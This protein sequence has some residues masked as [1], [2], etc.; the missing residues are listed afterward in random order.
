MNINHFKISALIVVILTL[1]TR[2]YQLET[3]PPHLSNDEISIAYDAYSIA[4]TGR[5]E[6]N[7]ILPLSFQSHNTYK[8]PLYIYLTAPLTLI[9]PNTIT[10]A[11]LLSALVGSLTVILTGLLVFRLTSTH[12]L[13]LFSSA[14]LALTPWHIFTSRLALEANLALFFLILGIYLFV[15]AS[16]NRSSLA[17]LM[18]A[19]LSLVASMYAYHSEWILSPL[20]FIFLSFSYLR[21]DHSKLFLLFSL[22]ILLSLPLLSDY[23]HN[24]NTTVRAN[25]ELIWREASLKRKLDN[26]DHP[27]AQILL[28]TKTI[29]ENYLDH[30]NPRHLF[31]NGLALFEPNHPYQPGLF[32]FI[33]L[34]LFVLGWFGLTVFGRYRNLVIFLALIS[35]ITSVITLGGIGY[36]RYLPAVVF[37]NII[38][39]SGFLIIWRHHS[40]LLKSFF[41]SLTS[42]AFMYFLLLYF[43]H[44]PLHSGESFQYGYRQAADYIKTMETDYERI[45]I[46]PRF[47]S[48]LQFAGVPHLYFAYFNTL[49]P[50]L[51]LNRQ[52]DQ[53]GLRFGK[54]HV[55]EVDWNLETIIPNSLYLL[56]AASQPAP[57]SLEILTHI[58]YPNGKPAFVIYGN[59][60]TA[61]PD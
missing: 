8:A 16:Q 32:L 34:P 60:T 51:L 40:L 50:Q 21:S 39:A 59:H 4:R 7:H 25:T 44:F 36:T 46:E 28:I 56:P 37:F 14:A 17:L 19:T 33:T 53:S 43:F 47:G 57:P 10:T 54:Y 24:L 52:A 27:F 23:L 29:A 3:I 9:L 15:W 2:L 58:S 11:R 61:T 35:P 20:I 1:F 12:S 5:D 30:L 49:D 45:I 6:H 26:L 41:L 18:L 31:F 38:I 13:A 22:F 42:I 48:Y 55:K